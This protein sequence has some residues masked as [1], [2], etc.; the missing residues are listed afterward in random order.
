MTIEIKKKAT[1]AEWVELA[2]G[3]RGAATAYQAFFLEWEDFLK[4]IECQRAS[5]VSAVSTRLTA[6]CIESLYSAK[7]NE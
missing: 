1:A 6:A 7:E 4:G 2:Y 5:V 3:E